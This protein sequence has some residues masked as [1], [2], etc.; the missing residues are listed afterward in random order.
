MNLYQRVLLVGMP[1]LMLSAGASAQRYK[2]WQEKPGTWCLSAGVGTTRYAGD[3]N[4]R[5]DLSHLRLGAALNVGVAYRLSYKL[6]FRTEAQLYYIYGSHR[7]TRIEYNNL[8]FHSLNP[9]VWTGL[10]YD[11]WPIDDP[12]RATIPYAFAGVGLTYLTPKATYKGQSY[13][14]APL[15]TESVEYN[16]LPVMFRYGLGLPVVATERFRINIE[17]SY[18]HV[19]SDYVDDVSTIYPDR[20][21]MEPLAAALSDRRLEIGQTPN[22]IGA[23]RGNSNRND[24]YFIVSGRLIFILITPGQR[25][26]RRMI[27][28]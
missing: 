28:R 17:G 11:F 18:T 1:W 7:H 23:Q 12:Y 2:I 13:S 25:S 22:S 8:S 6:T 10:Q 4:E 24:G 20:T 14:L 9:D 19:M 15:R 21:T 27:G 16:R 5:G 26:Y 3:M